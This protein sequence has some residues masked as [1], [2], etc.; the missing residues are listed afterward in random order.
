[1]HARLA[2]RAGHIQYSSLTDALELEDCLRDMRAAL[3]GA[4]LEVESSNAEY[5]PG[6]IEINIGHADAMTAA[7]NTV[8]YKSIVKQ[9]AVQ[10]G[11][12]ATFMPKPF[13]E[14]SGIGHAHP[15]ES[16]GR[17]RERLREL[18]TRHRTR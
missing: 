10:H 12:R 16:P 5:G 18:L 15:H 1:M 6:Q 17:R 4:G 8:L 3:L 2:A 14:Q 7:D 9:V 11:M 13:F